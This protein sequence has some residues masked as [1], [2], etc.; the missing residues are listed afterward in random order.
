M[1]KMALLLLLVLTGLVAF[2]LLNRQGQEEI[3]P[4]RFL[5]EQTALYIEH[6]D[7]EAFVQDF[8][9]SKLGLALSSID[10]ELLSRELEIEESFYQE[11]EKARND[12]TEFLDGQIFKQMLSKKVIVSLLPIKAPG[13]KD[14][15]VEARKRL[16][17]ILEPK[18]NSSLID[19]IGYLN[20]EG[21]DQTS[22]QHGDHLVKF[23]HLEDGE[24]LVSVKVDGLVLLS[25]N[26]NIIF[27][28][29][30]RFDQGK[31]SLMTHADFKYL[32]EEHRDSKVFFY[33]SIQS[34]RQ[35]IPHFIQMLDEPEQKLIID[36]MAGG[37]GWRTLSFGIDAGQDTISD[38]ATIFFDKEEIDAATRELLL[39]PPEKN[40]TLAMVP[41]EAVVYYWTNTFNLS[42]I[43]KT[44]QNSQ[45]D[46]KEQQLKMKKEITKTIG[47]DP[48]KFFALFGS[49]IAFFLEEQS[50]ISF[51]PLPGFSAMMQLKQPV[52]A[53]HFVENKLKELHIPIHTTTY[54]QKELRYW[55]NSVQQSFQPV[56][57][58]FNEY[59]YIA[60]SVKL[61]K[62]MIDTADLGTGLQN[63][64]GFL[65]VQNNS[66]LGKNNSVSFIRFSSFIQMTKELVNWGGMI[67]GLQNRRVANRSKILI[68]QLINPILDGMTM[69][70]TVHARS[71]TTDDKIVFENKTILVPQ[72]T[73]NE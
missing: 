10:Y 45:G 50:E 48:E 49:K 36:K 44:I 30:D 11:F 42:T 33:S 41:A 58:I 22:Q 56:Y 19:L 38:K 1:K 35:Q 70:S 40:E 29:L 21:T 9:Q 62:R 17:V 23:H 47:M 25:Y 65:A 16:L 7:L 55:G 34:I 63:D 61:M 8:K 54:K 13:S 60:S 69:F 72:Q 37:K 46:Q 3:D 64:P 28:C 73:T 26:E 18:L 52:K 43:W 39:V 66:F 32:R 12:V 4:A 31:Q 71:Y 53:G 67:L 24:T 59:L 2:V 57:A 5:P 20:L 51:I 6:R 68:D 14:P 15:L 27:G